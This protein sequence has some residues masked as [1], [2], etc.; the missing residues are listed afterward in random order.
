M[1]SSL[2]AALLLFWRCG[3]GGNQNDRGR[4]ERHFA[5]VLGVGA[6]RRNGRGRKFG[7][8]VLWNGPAQE[9]EYGR[10]IQ[11]VDSMVARRVDG[12]AIAAAERKA[13]V[14]PIDR[15]GGWDSR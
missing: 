11:I 7:V 10:Q 12:F 9:T 3:W 15:A 6:S 5:A 13:L 14:Q 1:R 2:P 8:K 4:S